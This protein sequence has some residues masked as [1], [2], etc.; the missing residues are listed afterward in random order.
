MGIATTLRGLP[1]LAIHDVKPKSRGN[2]RPGSVSS[3]HDCNRQSTDDSTY[4]S[5][6]NIGSVVS[7]VHATPIL[8]YPVL[9]WVRLGRF[10]VFRGLWWTRI[11]IEDQ[12]YAA[13]IMNVVGGRSSPPDLSYRQR[14]HAAFKGY[15]E[16]PKRLLVKHSKSQPARCVYVHRFPSSTANN[17]SNRP[18]Q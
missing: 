3:W 14:F 15:V 10:N 16:N 18:L 6:S 1:Y 2:S 13:S 8:S 17:P 4:L 11:K 9:P 12:V 7:D 5:S